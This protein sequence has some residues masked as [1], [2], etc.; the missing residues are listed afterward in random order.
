M[1]RGFIKAVFSLI[2]WGASGAIAFYLDPYVHEMLAERIHNQ[3]LAIVASSLGVFVVIFI[4]IAMI[5]APIIH[6]MRKITGGILDRLLGFCFGAARGLLI[7]CLIFF[8]ISLTSKMLHLGK[9]PDRPGPEWFAKAVT[10]PVLEKASSMLVAF[11]P[12][13]MPKQLEQTVDKFKDVT[14]ASLGDEL[15]I[16]SGNAKTLS[17]E[18]RKTIKQVIS[19]LSKDDL[20]EVYKKYDSNP[21]G[22][23]EFEK[24]EIFKEI[25]TLYKKNLQDNKIDSG[26]VVL[27][28]KLQELEKS[29]NDNKSGD[30]D[31]S[32]VDSGYKTD[33][34]NQMD[35]L[36]DGVK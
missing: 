30:A 16:S 35:R 10:Y 34:V 31:K 13:D 1:F 29:L 4:I 3:K 12:V 17:E 6:A 7:I 9:D 22:I 26:K 28:D 19:A 24:I 11:A 18:D 8:S 33:S 23:S 5:N 14:L 36:V 27:T 21:A 20:A 15:Q 25:V 32:G 2:T